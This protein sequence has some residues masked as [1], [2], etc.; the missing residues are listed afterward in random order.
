M[1]FGQ[2][3]V[4]KKSLIKLLHGIKNSGRSQEEGQVQVRVQDPDEDPAR[5]RQ[6]RGGGPHRAEEDLPGPVRDPGSLHLGR[7]QVNI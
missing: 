7:A 1:R 6:D 2:Y 3:D 5:R 4:I